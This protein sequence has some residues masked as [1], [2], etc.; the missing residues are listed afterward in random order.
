M[1]IS[2]TVAKL[3][4]LLAE[5]VEAD[6]GAPDLIARLRQ[7]EAM[8][9]YVDQQRLDLWEEGLLPFR[10]DT[11][12]IESDDSYAAGVAIYEL[13]R[14]NLFAEIDDE[15]TAQYYDDAAAKLTALGIPG[16]PARA[17]VDLT[18]W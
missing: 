9:T 6:R 2:G 5:R 10:Q 7:L 8:P 3:A 14:L 13:G 16:V 18:D 1:S 11:T 17:D 12:R 4:S 15:L